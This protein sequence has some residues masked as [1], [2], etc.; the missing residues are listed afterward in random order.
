MTQL[1]YARQNKI[2]PQMEA[3]AKKENVD[4]QLVLDE[5]AKGRAVICANINHK[6]LKPIVIGRKFTTKINANLGLSDIDSDLTK[7]IDKLSSAIH[8]GADVVMDLSTS[9]NLRKILQAFIDNS[10]VPVGTVPIY[11]TLERVEKIEDITP[12]L[13]LEIIEEEAC[14][15]V[16]FMTIHA[17]LLREHVPLALNR[18]TG[19]VSRGGAMLAKW[20]T[21]HKKENPLYTHFTDVCKIFKKYDV[22]FSLGDGLRPGS[23][24]DA[25][26]EA[27]YAELD[28]LGELVKVSRDYGVQVM[29]EGP[30]HVPLDKIE[31]NMQR[32]IKVCHD[33]PFYVLGP[34][35][36]DIAAGYDHI[37]SAIGASIAAWKGAAFLCYVT[38]SEH[39]GL[40]TLED[41]RQGV[42]AYKIAAHSGDIAKG[43]KGAR[44]IDDKISTARRNLDWETQIKLSLDPDRAR[45]YHAQSQLKMPK[46][47]RKKHK[48]CSMC[49]SKFCAIEITNSIKEKTKA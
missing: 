45:N 42:M 24:A 47:D 22:T 38:P 16:D 9:S 32:A 4:P 28:V 13:L 3:S 5:V 20:M 49:G 40:P 6:N 26:D 36:T 34:V 35:V 41:V 48:Y 27:Q 23:L 46:Q 14:Q 21:H 19:I 43:I 30:G 2:T 39:L 11:K 10:P 31:E 7:E 17:G 8:W 15:G 33:A 37:S 44:D 1:E 29:V 18:T 25:S 12:Q